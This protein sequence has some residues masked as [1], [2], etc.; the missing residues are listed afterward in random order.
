MKE[1]KFITTVRIANN[2]AKL[3]PNY[4]INCF[5]PKLLAKRFASGNS[6][7]NSLR[8]FGFEYET[9]EIKNVG[10]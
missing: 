8:E 5:T 10:I 4:N 1:Y 6:Q 7:R 3:Y 2:V 9:K